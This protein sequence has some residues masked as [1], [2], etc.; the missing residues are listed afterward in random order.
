MS[1]RNRQYDHDSALQHQGVEEKINELFP[2]ISYVYYP[3]TSRI[4]YLDSKLR[5]VLGYDYQE[6]ELSQLFSFIF[7]EDL[8]HVKDEFNKICLLKDNETRSYQCRIKHRNNSERCFKTV[9]TVLNRHVDGRPSTILFVAYDI[10]DVVNTVPDS[11]TAPNQQNKIAELER[12]N[13]ELEEFAYAAAHDL[14]EPLRKIYTFSERLRQKQNQSNEKDVNNYLDRILATATNMRAL[15]DSLLEFS[16]LTHVESSFEY[17]NLIDLIEEAKAEVGIKAQG[18]HISFS[19]DQLPVVEVIRTEMRQLFINLFSNAL[20]F[21]QKETEPEIH[22]TFTYL[23]AEVKDQLKLHRSIPYVK[24][25]VK[26]NG[27]GFEPEFAEKIFQPFKRLHGKA[28]YPG[29]G[30]GLSICRKIVEHHRGL[31]YAES[32]T[33]EGATFTIIIPE[34]QL[35]PV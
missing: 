17:I 11:P 23:P 7:P 35:R 31:I 27:I 32:S 22:V 18:K 28:E 19:K 4:K 24:I 15:I 1:V 34:R 25:T 13:R 12:S 5:D 16:G 3:D 8:T 10:T 14:Q 21:Q 2:V 26:D 20:K 29:S 33:G 6:T 9:G 30:I